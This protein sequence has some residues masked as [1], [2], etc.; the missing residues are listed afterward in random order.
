VSWYEAEKT[1]IE[2]EHN[3]RSQYLFKYY[4]DIINHYEFLISQCGACQQ[5][6]VYEEKSREVATEFDLKKQAEEIRYQKELADLESRWGSLQ[7]RLQTVQKLIE[8]LKE[9]EE[10]D[11][12][13]WSSYYQLP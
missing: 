1:K 3:N 11:D 13:F 8:Q 9:G 2:E 10:P 4:I 12:T 5:A 6:Q 7:A